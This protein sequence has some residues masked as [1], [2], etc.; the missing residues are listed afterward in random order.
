MN[1][2]NICVSVVILSIIIL[3]ISCS[4][5]KTEWKG[6]IAEVDGVTVVKNPKEPMYAE[7]VFVLEEELSIGE[8][9]GN[10]EYM[11]SQIRDI[12]VDEEERIYV[13]EIKESHIK[14]FDKNG[15]YLRTIGKKGQGPGE[16]GM[17]SFMSITKQNEVLVEDP[18]NR[19]LTYYSLNGDFLRST[20]TAKMTIAQTKIDSFG[21][22][23][24]VVL[25][26][27]KKAFEIR[28]FDPD[29]NNYICS[30]GAESISRDNRAYN[31]FKSPMR[32][33][34]S[35]DNS[36]VCG[37]PAKYELQVFNPEGKIIRKI[38]KEYDPVEI[39]QEEIEEAK[40]VVPPG[41]RLEIPKYHNSFVRFSLTDEERIFVQTR[42][43]T[44][45]HE[46]YYYD[47]FDHDG[48]YIA[49]VPLKMRPRIW[50]KNKL[51]TIEE[52]EDGYQYVKR[53]QVYWKI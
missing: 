53:Y 33:A 46:R 36:V 47:I 37:F 10:E 23:L 7:N 21:N 28:K 42:E 2:R 49:K 45:D 25:N 24:G 29:F 34:V 40:K 51:Y 9:E 26:I 39:T 38:I 41:R 27:E 20:S 19:R 50:R 31:P 13:L 3:F 12:A 5:E 11:F 14:V 44:G 30:F 15:S 35:S 18:M 1:F 6:T 17:P 48:R 52:D 22:I 16:I 8:A 43:R 4:Q 32:W